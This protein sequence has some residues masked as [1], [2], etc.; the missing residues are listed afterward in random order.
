LLKTPRHTVVVEMGC[1]QYCH[2]GLQNAVKKMLDG[3]NKVLGQMTDRLNIFINIDGLSISKSSS[4]VLWPILCSDTVLKSV[5]I[6]GAYYGQTKPQCNNDFLRQFVDEAIFLI[7][8]GFFYNGIKI[9]I[10]FYGL[11]CDAPA[12]AFVLSIKNHTG[13]N[14]CTRCIIRAEHLNGRL[15]FPATKIVDAL[16]TDDDFAINMTIFKLVKQSRFLISN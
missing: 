6:V 1:G 8:N 2:Y 12:K 3:Y 10:N 14:S 7:N 15:C 13:Y 11:I 4:S 9:K 5:F 16:R